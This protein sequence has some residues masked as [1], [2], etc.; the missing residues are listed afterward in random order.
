MF[1]IHIGIGK[2]SPI[3]IGKRS[4]KE[5]TIYLQPTLRD[6]HWE[7]IVTVVSQFWV[8]YTTFVWSRVWLKTSANLW[9]NEVCRTSH[10]Y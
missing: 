1:S 6:A 4:P 5:L 2:G 7:K 3:G 10:S 8:E 9:V